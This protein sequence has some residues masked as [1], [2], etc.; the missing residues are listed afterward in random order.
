VKRTP[1]LL[2]YLRSFLPGLR[3]TIETKGELE[4]AIMEMDVDDRQRAQLDSF[5]LQ[6]RAMLIASDT[7]LV[8][9]LGLGESALGELSEHPVAPVPEDLLGALPPA[10]AAALGGGRST[11][12]L[13]LELDGLHG[14]DVRG[15][16]LDAFG[17]GEFMLGDRERSKALLSLMSAVSSFSFWSD[18]PDG[19]MHIA[20]RAFGDGKTAEGQKAYTARLNVEDGESPAL[21]YGALRS[22]YRYSPRAHTY[23]ARAGI[24]GLQTDYP[25]VANLLMVDSLIRAARKRDASTHGVG[26]WFR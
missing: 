4:L 2:P 5:E 7:W 10:M 25:A 12:A 6:P 1:E 8:A 23:V 11:F 16:L 14:P 20:V 9:S 18:V 24:G 21:V 26:A 19:A 22:E 13:H 3:V 17:D 15:Y